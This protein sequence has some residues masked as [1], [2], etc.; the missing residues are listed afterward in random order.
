MS[1]A[2]FFSFTTARCR[3][4]TGGT[5]GEDPDFA[6]ANGIRICIPYVPE[7]HLRAALIEFCAVLSAKCEALGLPPQ[8]S[9]V[10]G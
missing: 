8:R 2:P 4:W 3:A 9:A 6:L 7:E 10:I 5:A 1:S